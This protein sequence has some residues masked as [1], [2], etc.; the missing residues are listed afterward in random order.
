MANIKNIAITGL[1]A[2]ANNISTAQTT[3][4]AANLT[5]TGALASGG[6][7]TLTPPGR[8]SFFSS[9]DI[10]T[11]IFTIT[12]TD[13]YGNAQTATVTG[14]N[15]VAV[16][17]TVDFATVTKI[18]TSG[19]VG[20]NVTVGTN[21]V[22]ST[23][24]WPCDYRTGKIPVISVSLSAGAVLTYTVEFTQT[25]LND[26]YNFLTPAQQ[27]AQAQTAIVF[28]STDTNVVNATTNQIS[29]FIDEVAG[30]R[31]TLNSYT[32]GTATLTIITPFNAVA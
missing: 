20:T 18:A 17:T 28:P 5:I 31:L 25:N 11:I 30:I 19:A 10:H 27:I 14:V 24:W 1:A 2:S 32:S 4:G 8:V 29:N 12:G 13:R 21:G 26:V 7:A 6:V 9:G 16:A 23:P 3:A 22:A 15:N